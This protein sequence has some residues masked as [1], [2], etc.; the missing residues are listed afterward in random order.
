MD[1]ITCLLTG[2]L[3]VIF[4]FFFFKLFQTLFLFIKKKNSEVFVLFFSPNSSTQY[5]L[6]LLN[7]LQLRKEHEQQRQRHS[8][9]I[10]ISHF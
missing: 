6:L 7:H 2:P 9:R 5:N 3:D 10:I 1:P 4:T 8:R